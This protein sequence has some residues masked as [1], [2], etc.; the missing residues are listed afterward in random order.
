MPRRAAK[1][2]WMTLGAG[3]LAGLGACMGDPAPDPA[4]APL[5]VVLDG[6]I[7][8][9]DEVAAGTHDVAV[10][11]VGTLVVTDE[12]GNLEMSLTSGQMQLDTTVQTYTFVC[13]V[14]GDETTATL[15]SVP[16]SGR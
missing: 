14:D 15:R 9:R 4:T 12:G 8:N 11:G 2:S 7:L 13:Q 5:E 1:V 3:A 10:V 6:C 16:A